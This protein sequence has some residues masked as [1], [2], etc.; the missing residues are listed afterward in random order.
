PSTTI[1]IARCDAGAV[2]DC[3]RELRHKVAVTATPESAE[4]ALGATEEL[5]AFFYVSQGSVD[6][7]YTSGDGAT[8]TTVLG[9]TQ[10]EPSTLITLWTVLRDDRGGVDWTS[11]TLKVVPH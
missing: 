3:P 1:P 6:D 11:R 7:A 9:A 8:F 10:A 4:S 5:V 2:A